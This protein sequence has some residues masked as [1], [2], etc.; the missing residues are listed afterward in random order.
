MSRPPEILF[1]PGFDGNATLREPFVA[2][3][4]AHHPARAIGYPN[5]TLGSLRGYCRY[6]AAQASEDARHIL[7]AESFSGLVAARWAATDPHVEAVVLC[8]SFA[9]NPVRWLASVGAALPEIVRLGAKLLRAIP[10]ATRDPRH[11]EW[12]REFNDTILALDD[13]VIAER[14]RIIADEDV[15]RELAGLRIPIVLLQFDGDQVVGMRARRELESVCRNAEV[16]RIPGPHYALE[17]R[18]RECAEAI[19]QRIR[20]LFTPG[21]RDDGMGAANT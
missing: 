16:V 20:T 17:I 12:S 14:L 4:N 3:L 18:P 2:A 6:A 19:G 8:A 1:L 13:A 10:P 9:R 7:V 15:S 21:A 11:L 5:A